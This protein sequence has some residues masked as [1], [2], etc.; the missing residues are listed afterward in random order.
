MVNPLDSRYSCSKKIPSAWQIRV[1]PRDPWENKI[2]IRVQEKSVFSVSI[3][4]QKLFVRTAVLD[5]SIVAYES[6]DIA[7]D[8]SINNKQ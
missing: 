2:I 6:G 3:R 4:V 8:G 1:Y 7:C 5:G